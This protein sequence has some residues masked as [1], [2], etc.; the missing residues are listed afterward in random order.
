[1]TA[2]VAAAL[3]L[4]AA[5]VTETPEIVVV[6][7]RLDRV[8]VD[9]RRDPEGR[10]HCALD[11][12]IGVPSLDADLCRAVTKC[13]RHGATTEDATRTCVTRNKASLLARF[14]RERE[15]LR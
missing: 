4:A 14:E 7:E 3:A 13:V 2:L 15:R 1:M 6:A 12:S 10:W 9:V 5:A 11:G 8:R